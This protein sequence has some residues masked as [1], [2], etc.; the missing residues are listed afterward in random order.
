MTILAN[1]FL[2]NSLG[3]FKLMIESYSNLKL[4]T[5]KNF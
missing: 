1:N 3:N 2:T 5:K 4:F